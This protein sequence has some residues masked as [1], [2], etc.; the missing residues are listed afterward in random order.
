MLQTL[1]ER[2]ISSDEHWNDLKKYSDYN[3]KEE[4]RQHES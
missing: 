3:Q 1:N 4:A 2:R